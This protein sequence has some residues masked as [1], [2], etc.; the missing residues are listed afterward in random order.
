MSWG[1]SQEHIKIITGRKSHLLLLE[2]DLIAMTVDG[3]VL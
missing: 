3:F 1:F 2:F